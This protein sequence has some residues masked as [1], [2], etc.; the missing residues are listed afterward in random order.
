MILLSSAVQTTG[1]VFL[2]VQQPALDSRNY[3]KLSGRTRPLVDVDFISPEGFLLACLFHQILFFV[4]YTS[5]FSI[6]FF[7]LCNSL[8][9]GTD[10]KD[11]VRPANQK[12][13]LADE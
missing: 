6:R 2:F 5:L 1:V 7:Q 11:L 10:K 4:S 12:G 13:R 3:T 9:A 8:V